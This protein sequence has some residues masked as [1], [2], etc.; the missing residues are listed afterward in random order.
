MTSKLDLDNILPKDTIAY[1]IPGT[2]P[3]VGTY[4]V[5]ASLDFGGSAPAVYDGQIEIKAQPAKAA[6]TAPAATAA[7]NQ[8]VAANQ[9]AAA[10]ANT[11]A[12]VNT[13]AGN[14][15]SN[16]AV[17]AAANPASASAQVA[18]AASSDNGMLMGIVIGIA[19]MLG[20][21]TL[22]LGGYILVSRGKKG[23]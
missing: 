20:L 7:A 15:V 3:P 12:N 16:S 11:N 21:T 4:K 19:V 13:S 23:N 17:T 6:A 5:H 8:P 9:P 22:G 14:N 10:S 2:L 18:P 1:P